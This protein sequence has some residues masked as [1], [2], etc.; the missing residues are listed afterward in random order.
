MKEPYPWLCF[1]GTVTA[2]VDA[3]DARDAYV[4]FV[5]TYFPGDNGYLGRVMLPE[6]DEVRI[7]PLVASDADWLAEYDDARFERALARVVG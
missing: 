4:Q 2:L 6:P 7:R 1:W 3:R 5:T